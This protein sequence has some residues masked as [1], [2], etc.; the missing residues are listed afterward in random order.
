MSRGAK[1]A[2]TV[3]GVL[4]VLFAVGAILCTVY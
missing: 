1:I 3:V 4:L 2:L